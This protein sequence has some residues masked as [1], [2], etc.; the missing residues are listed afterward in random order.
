[1]K[2]VLAAALAAFL[3]IAFG[4][5]ES[6]SAAEANVRANAPRVTGP[7]FYRGPMLR[8]NAPYRNARHRG[9]H[10]HHHHHR[11]HRHFTGLPVL[12]GPAVIYQNGAIEIPDEEPVAAIPQVPVQPVVYRVGSS[13]ACD[14]QQ[15][16]VRGEAGRTTVNIWRC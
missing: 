4:T 16:R 7:A 8:F 13:G 14:V 5:I 2:I 1:M 11:R 10:H 6:A 9:G 15:V 3:V 12:A